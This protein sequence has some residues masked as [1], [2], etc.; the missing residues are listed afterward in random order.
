MRAFS[1]MHD[2]FCCLRFKLLPSIP[3]APGK[4]FASDDAL[5]NRRMEEQILEQERLHEQELLQE[6]MAMMQKIEQTQMEKILAGGPAP[7]M[8]SSAAQPDYGKQQ[9]G[10]EVAGEGF[11]WPVSPREQ[12]SLTIKPKGQ[13]ASGTSTSKSAFFCCISPPH[14]IME[15]DDSSGASS[16]KTPGDQAGRFVRGGGA[17][18]KGVHQWATADASEMESLSPRSPL[19]II[20]GQDFSCEEAADREM[21]ENQA[22][23][24]AVD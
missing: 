14:G 22:G 15:E 4:Q 12:Q 2:V 24:C 20:A 1:C 23:I 11:G 6:Q 18:R 21:L 5:R 16:S 13:P 17:R 19:M 9:S 8:L 7:L 10:R 3:L